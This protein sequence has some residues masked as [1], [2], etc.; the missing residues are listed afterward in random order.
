MQM[1]RLPRPKA[2]NP[3]LVNPLW[4]INTPRA[5]AAFSS[6]FPLNACKSAAAIGVFCHLA[7]SR[8]VSFPSTKRIPV[9]E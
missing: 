4:L 8:Y 7:S 3:S 6:T 2:C 5:Q 1:M 9:L